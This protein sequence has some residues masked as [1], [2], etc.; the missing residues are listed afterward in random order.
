MQK[1]IILLFHI[2]RSLLELCNGKDISI[3]VVSDSEPL[4]DNNT[5]KGRAKITKKKQSIRTR[6]R[7]T[8]QSSGHFQ[9]GD[10]SKKKINEYFGGDS[11]VMLSGDEDDGGNDD[12]E[13][14]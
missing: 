5:I 9:K 3:E 7:N 1:V 14:S 4:T 13:D 11:T 2:R 6:K 12:E 10:E 8:L